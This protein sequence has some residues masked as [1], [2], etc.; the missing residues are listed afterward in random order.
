[1]ERHHEHQ[2]KPEWLPD[3]VYI[4]ANM[5]VQMSSLSKSR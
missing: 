3:Q 1:M 5:K 2:D 4:E